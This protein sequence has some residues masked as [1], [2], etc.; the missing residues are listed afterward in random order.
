MTHT[1]QTAEAPDAQLINRRT[2]VPGYLGRSFIHLPHLVR[3]GTLDDRIGYQKPQ[4]PDGLSRC[5]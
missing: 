1:P 5:H 4:G 2:T 3:M